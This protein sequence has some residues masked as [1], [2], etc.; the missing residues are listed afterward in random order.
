M[1]GTSKVEYCFIQACIYFLHYIA[2]LCAI[3]CVFVILIQP[4]PFTVPWPVGVWGFA[5]ILFLLLHHVKVR[6]LQREALHPEPLPRPERKQ[7][8][9]LCHATV[10][11]PERYLRQWF[12]GSPLSDI[13]RGN[14][15]ELYRWAFLNTKE[16]SPNDDEEL[17][18]YVDKTELLLGREF[19]RGYGKARS[20]RVTLDQV[21]ILYRPL[22]WYVCV[23]TVDFITQTYLLWHSFDF[24]RLPVTKS[25]TVFPPRPLTWFGRHRSPANTLTYWYKPHMSKAGLPV[26]F[27]HGIGIGLY[28]YTK[29]MVQI[30][31]RCKQSKEDQQ[32]GIIAIEIMPVSFRI[33]GAALSR[34]Q[35]CDEIQQI[36]AKHGW[37]KAILISHSYGSVICSQLLRNPKLARLFGPIILVDPVS[38]LLHLPDVAFNFTCRKPKRAN[39]LQLYF[40]AST[41]MGVAHTLGRHFFWQENILWKQ[42]MEGRKVTVSLAGKDLIVD[43]EA[44]GR[45]LATDDYSDSD[46]WKDRTWKG[47]GLEILWFE[48]LDHGQ[49]FDSRANRQSLVDVVRS[50]SQS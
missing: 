20:L 46:Q 48:D 29:F 42:D 39:E 12:R 50:Y 6:A 15:K 36:L 38:L 49:V 7:L 13:R 30:N 5:E 25:F 23:F 27:I 9:E 8:F 40:F 37:E 41:D 32:I 24:Y 14:V 28:P 43:T 26:V 17:E 3:Y 44:V 1:I 47:Q 16:I 22:F 21:Q 33:T 18:E 34:Q 10:Q 45:Y 19:Q 2:P 35:M 4:S 11:H 31:E